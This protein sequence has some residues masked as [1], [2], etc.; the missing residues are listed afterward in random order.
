MKNIFR[1][2][3]KSEY[4]KYDDPDESSNVV[5]NIINNPE[6]EEVLQ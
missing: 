4:C 6:D 3:L 1:V 2:G 5:C